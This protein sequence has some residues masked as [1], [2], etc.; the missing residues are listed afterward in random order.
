MWNTRFSFIF[1]LLPPEG[2][3]FQTQI[4][5]LYNSSSFRKS[6][7]YQS[8]LIAYQVMFTRGL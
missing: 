5:F 8:I 3:A 6:G 7:Q 2:L 1:Q 4:A